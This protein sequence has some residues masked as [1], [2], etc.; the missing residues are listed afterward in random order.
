LSRVTSWI[1]IRV[2]FVMSDFR[3][4]KWKIDYLEIPPCKSHPIG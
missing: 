4:S 3:A 1:F 2:M